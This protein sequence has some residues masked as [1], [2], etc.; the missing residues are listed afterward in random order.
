VSDVAVTWAKA[1]TCMSVLRGRKGPDGV[2]GPDRVRPDRN[3]KQVLVHMASY[4]D[5]A[6]EAWALVSVLALEMDVDER[7]VERGRQALVEDGLLIKTGRTKVYEGKIVPIYQLPLET[8]HA[9]TVRRIKAERAAERAVD[10]A[11]S[12][13]VDKAAWGDTRVTPDGP[14]GVTRVSPQTDAGVAPRGDTGVTQIGKGISQGLTP[15][16]GERAS[17]ADQGVGIVADGPHLTEAKAAWHRKAPGMVADAP[18]RSAWTTALQVRG[19]SE[20][21]LCAAVTACVAGD[22]AFGWGRAPMLHRWLAEERYLSWDQ[23][24]FAGAAAVAGSA[25]ATW[26]GPDRVSHAHRPHGSFPLSRDVYGRA[27]RGRSQAKT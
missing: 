16:A 5:A 8:G 23:A 15:F 9:S 22:A 17:E 11:A 20:A 14:L 1:Q 3:A 2:K 26:S 27:G 10:L 21:R 18:V 6:G 19:W 25:R 24:E 12:G 13:H 4:A 7:T